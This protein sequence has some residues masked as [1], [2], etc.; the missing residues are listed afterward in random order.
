M[1]NRILSSDQ[2]GC[3]SSSCEN[4]PGDRS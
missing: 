3:E 2:S 1:T 4:S